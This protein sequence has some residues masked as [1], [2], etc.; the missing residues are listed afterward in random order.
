MLN[1]KFSKK[2]HSHHP[3]MKVGGVMKKMKVQTPETPLV[4]NIIV[5]VHPH[6]IYPNPDLWGAVKINATL[7]RQLAGEVYQEK[8]SLPLESRLRFMKSVRDHSLGRQHMGAFNVITVDLECRIPS[9]VAMIIAGGKFY[10]IQQQTGRAVKKLGVIDETS[11]FSRKDVME[12]IT[13]RFKLYWQLT[14]DVKGFKF[15]IRVQAAYKLLP[16]ATETMLSGVFSLR[17]IKEYASLQ[18]LSYLPQVIRKFSRML[19]EK[20]RDALPIMARTDVEGLSGHRNRGVENLIKTSD[21]AQDRILYYNEH[22]FLL[23][24]SSPAFKKHEHVARTLDEEKPAKLIGHFNLPDRPIIEILEDLRKRGKSAE[25]AKTELEMA[26]LSFV[27]LVDLS[28]FIDDLRHT[29]MN[30]ATQ[31]IYEALDEPQFH[32]PRVLKNQWQDQL[33]EKCQES[34]SLYHDL[35]DDGIPKQDALMVIPHLTKISYVETGDL[36]S[37]LNYWGL[38]SCTS[39][40]PEIQ[41]LAMTTIQ[42]AS[43]VLEGVNALTRAKNRLCY[44]R[45]RGLCNETSNTFEEKPCQIA[46]V[47][48]IYAGR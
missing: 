44:A 41:K 46:G 42:E 33:L 37:W 8:D 6:S 21:L 15:D 38:R 25:L 35:V 2:P 24:E 23:P 5:K 34:V 4:N 32:I 36:W 13:R 47:D 22:G 43:K 29:R 28:G 18:N 17:T 20:T 26:Y 14:A 10:N 16:L 39:A 48:I 12:D 19:D 3:M 7:K 27:K 9:I 30:R 1:L 45:I 40:R 31:S 11:L